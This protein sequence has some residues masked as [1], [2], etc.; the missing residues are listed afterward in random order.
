MGEDACIAYSRCGRINFCTKGENAGIRVV[1][2]RFR[3]K[4]HS[5]GIFGSTGDINVGTKYSIQEKILVIDIADRLK[6]LCVG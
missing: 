5:A 3:E 1:M 6:G 2:G 4:K